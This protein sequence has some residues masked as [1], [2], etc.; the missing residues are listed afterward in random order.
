MRLCVAL[1]PPSLRSGPEQRECKYGAGGRG[2]TTLLTFV[3][4][5]STVCVRR[6]IEAGGRLGVC[7]RRSVGARIGYC[8]EAV[9]SGW[10]L[11]KPG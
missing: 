10:L 9:G 3:V 2:E 7:A 5:A 6:V 1:L 8:V 11:Y 4:S